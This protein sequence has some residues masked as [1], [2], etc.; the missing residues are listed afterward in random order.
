[1]N[2]A[3]TTLE[4]CWYLS[5]PWGQ[6][7]LP[8]KSNALERVYLRTTNTF[9]YCCGV[10]WKHDQWIYTI[11][12]GYKI[13]HAT[14][15]QIVGTGRMQITNLEKPAFVLG[16]RVMFRFHGNSTKQRLILGIRLVN[17]SWLYVVELVSP[18]L[19]K[20]I[21]FENRLALVR[22]KDLVRVNV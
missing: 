13:V 8:I 19:E 9:G 17:E 20:T 10:E 15:H 14:K 12:C 2:C 4:R 21:S 6:E 16:E 7:I 11:V 1:M 3:I 5:P 18:A 22:E